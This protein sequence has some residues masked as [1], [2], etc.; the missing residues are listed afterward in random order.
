MSMQSVAMGASGRDADLTEAGTIRVGM[1]MTRYWEDFTPGWTFENGPRALSAEEIIAFAREWDPQRYHTDE[2]A[3][4]ASPFGGLIAS[5]W[6]TACVGMRLMCDGYLADSS[7]VG[8]P[9]IEAIEFLKPVRPGDALRFRAEVLEARASR[10]RPDR[11]LVRWRWQVLNQ[12]GEVALSMLGTQMFLRRAQ[13][14]A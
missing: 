9:G 5:G 4:R 1:P 14:G 8:S 7:C 6:Q 10:S 13:P 11:G 2:A 12:R 3:A